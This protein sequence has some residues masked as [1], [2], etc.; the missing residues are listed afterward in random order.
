MKAQHL[1]EIEGTYGAHNYHPL[2]V[3]LEKGKGVWVWDVEG[4]K[5]MDCLAAY[6][7]VNQGHCHPKLIK[8]MKKQAQKLTLTSRAFRNNLWPL[9]AK[10][11]CEL[12]DYEMVLPMNSGA[13]AVETAIK[14]ARKWG[15][16]IKGVDQNQAEIVVCSGN[17]HGR[18]TTI[19]SFADDPSSYENYG[20]YTPGFKI[21]EYGDANAL[22]K[23]I[24]KN[25]VGFLVEPIQG[26]AGVVSPPAGFLKQAAEICRQN[27]V[28]L[29]CDEIQSG[30]GRTGKM[31]ASEH[32][33]VKPDMVTIG[34]A[35]SGGMYPVSA[36]LASND[37]LG[38]F[39]P[40]SHGSTYGGNPLACAVARQALK[41]L[42]EENLLD[43]AASLGAYALA[44]LGAMQSPYIDKVR[45]K[46][47]WIGVVLNEKAG[48]ARKFCKALQQQGILAKDTHENTIRLAPP[49]VINKKEL[50]WALQRLKS[51]LGE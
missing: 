44:E 11:L 24:D 16:K 2:D 8:A 42:V 21:I 6:S 27:R 36:T 19:V 47:L 50:D 30:L 34:K 29:I 49:L 39:E 15:Y 20:P 1:I 32:E 17:F 5:Y 33:G 10:E 4:K 41:T 23:A 3:V 14:A 40:G 25:T 18:T 37:I 12:L 38:V 7:A 45:G 35:L 46:G 13:E 31:L 22:E 9:F 43:N 26:E 48:G 51:V 28:L